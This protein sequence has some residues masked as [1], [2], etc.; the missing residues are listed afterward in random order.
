MPFITTTRCNFFRSYVMIRYCAREFEKKNIVIFLLYFRVISEHIRAK[1]H[2]IAQNA[3][4]VSPTSPTSGRM[5]KL[6]QQRNRMCVEDVG[7]RS[8]WRATSTSMRNLLA[9]AGNVTGLNLKN[10]GR[11]RTN[12]GTDKTQS[13][14]HLQVPLKAWLKGKWHGKFSNHPDQVHRQLIYYSTY[15]VTT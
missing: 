9:C 13:R 6:I 8:P 15:F 7:R 11:V 5:C 10:Q 4:N 2:S 14:I 3:E 1:N 12:T